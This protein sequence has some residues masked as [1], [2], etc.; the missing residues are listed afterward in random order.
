M[1]FEREILKMYFKRA[2]LKI[3]FEEVI[4]KMY[5]LRWQFWKCIF[6]E[7]I[8][9]FKMATLKIYFL[10]KQHWKCVFWGSNFEWVILFWYTLYNILSFF[11]KIHLTFVCNFCSENRSLKIKKVSSKT[12]SLHNSSHNIKIICITQQI[13]EEKD[14]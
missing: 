9:F 3:Y 10:R 13:W 12:G 6:E 1:F 11:N 14:L 4:S 5:F 7:A 8:L 2:I